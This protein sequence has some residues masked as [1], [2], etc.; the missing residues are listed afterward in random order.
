M[1]DYTDRLEIPMT[2]TKRIHAECEPLAD[3]VVPAPARAKAG[4]CG[5]DFWQ[6]PEALRWISAYLG[7]QPVLITVQDGTRRASL[8]CLLRRIP[9]GLALGSAYP[10][11]D[12]VGDTALFWQNGA[13][14]AT[15]LRAQGVVRLE[16]PFSG[17]NASQFESLDPNGGFRGQ[18]GLD[19]IRHVLDLTS[20]GRDPG[21]L[22]AQLAPNTRWAVRKAER[23]G[24]RIRPAVPADLNQVQAIYAAA[25]RAKGAPVNYG[26]E[27]FQGML[28]QLSTK[29]VARIYV[30]EVAGKPAGMAAVLHAST[31][32]HLIQLA[33]APEAQASRL[34]DLLVHSVI[35]AAVAEGCQYFDFM[36][37]N[38]TDT[39]LVS[40]KAKWAGRPEPIR[41]AILRVNRLTDFTIDLGRW[42]NVQRGKGLAYLRSAS[43][44]RDEKSGP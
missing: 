41:Y 34:S 22:A 29:G 20:A 39:G 4:S 37:S 11:A 38:P 26:P 36:A 35:Q 44:A 21:W 32:R 5:L 13:T 16:M 1:A 27:R 19:A 12:I 7:A 30:G 8:C 40:F 2:D 17:E 43:A 31:S 23:V 3:F 42:A 25:M 33:V 10:Y 28:G 14:I 6:S 15:A 24:G 9:L 18:A